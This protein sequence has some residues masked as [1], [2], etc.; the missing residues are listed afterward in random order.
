MTTD[1]NN[2]VVSR[3]NS[4]E[5]NVNRFGQKKVV[6]N[7]ENNLKLYDDILRQIRNNDENSNNLKYYAV[8]A[9]A[10]L[11]KKLNENRSKFESLSVFEQTNLLCNIVGFM[12]RGG[13]TGVD[14][15]LIGES[16]NT[17]IL[18]V[19]YNITDV[20]FAIIHRSPCGLTERIQKV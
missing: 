8:G 10:D 16:K 12:R 2:K 14:L 15:S 11:Y 4:Y 3:Q 20:D 6:V 13:S 17:C 18:R 7:K 19:G 9:Y 5:M 1:T